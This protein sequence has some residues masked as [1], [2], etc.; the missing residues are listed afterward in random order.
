[1]SFTLYDPNFKELTYPDGVKPLDILVSSIQKERITASVDGIPGHVNYGFNYKD[2]EVKLNFV[3]EHFYDT[4]DFRLQRDEIYNMLDS[5]PYVYI[6]DDKLPTRLLAVTIDAS[7]QIERYG[8]W[9]ST[10]EIE[11]VIYNLP[12]W[13]TKYTTQ[14]IQNTGYTALVDRYGMA[15]GFNIDYPNYSFTSSEFSVWNGG[16]VTIDYRNMPLNITIFGATSSNNFT[17]ENLTTGEKFVA[18]RALSNHTVNLKGAMFLL[19]NLN[20]LRESNRKFIKLVPGE[21][22]IKISNGTFKRIDFEFP[23]FYK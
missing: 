10:F 21:N 5:Y 7:Y 19:N 14:D 13:R 22:K 9:Y 12:F 4:F 17:V 1:M 8:Y 11:A 16:N 20:R 6:C 3:N 15:D 18:Q 2:R 23:F